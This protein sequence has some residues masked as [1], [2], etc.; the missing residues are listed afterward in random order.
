MRI[1]FDTNII[2]YAAGLNDKTRAERAVA[3]R[4]AFGPEQTI[5]PT[6]VIGELFQVLI[7]KFRQD[8]AIAF[9]ACDF[10]RRSGTVRAADETSFDEALVL[11]G[12]H[13]LQFWDALILTTAADANCRALFSEDM[14]HGFVHRGVTVI[15][16]F[17][18]PMHPLL[19]DALRHPR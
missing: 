12:N 7:G 9:Q 16:P 1:A 10:L 18:E 14:Q 6:Q 5:V 8:R 13:G 4:N 15:N 3:L 11:A 19:A 17:A 2:V